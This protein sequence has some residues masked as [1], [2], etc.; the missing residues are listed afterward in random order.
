MTHRETAIRLLRE[1]FSSNP[2]KWYDPQFIGEI[3]LDRCERNA[4][5]TAQFFCGLLVKANELEIK[6]GKYK[7]R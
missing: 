7:W 3:I 2:D 6:D 1:Y 4:K 5:S